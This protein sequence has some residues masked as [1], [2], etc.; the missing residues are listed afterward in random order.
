MT[1]KTILTR[2]VR[3]FDALGVERSLDASPD[4]LDVRDE[5]GRTWLHLCCSV[6]VTTRS[7][8]DRR[9]E[10]RARVRLLDRGLDMDDAAFTEDTWKATPVWFTVARGR[11]LDLA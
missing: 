11:N 4:L 10:R 8:V 5:R 3:S 9:G 2:Q 7:K 6:D 1:S